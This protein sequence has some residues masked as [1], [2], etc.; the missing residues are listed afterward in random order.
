MDMLTKQRLENVGG[1]LFIAVDVI[2]EIA[3]DPSLD[4]SRNEILENAKAMI[5]AATSLILGIAR[6]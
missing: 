4:D 5:M 6:E 2:R 3:D 1:S